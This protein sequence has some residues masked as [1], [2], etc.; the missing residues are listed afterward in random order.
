MSIEHLLNLYSIFSCLEYT[1]NF[2]VKAS[3]RELSYIG[4]WIWPPPVLASK[5]VIFLI[6]QMVPHWQYTVEKFL[7]RLSEWQNIKNTPLLILFRLIFVCTSL[8]KTSCTHSLKVAMHAWWYAS[9]LIWSTLEF[10][11]DKFAWYVFIH[12]I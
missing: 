11:N 5:T 12:V 1:L 7:W 8:L 10:D 2:A 6:K 4:H 9:W 3:M